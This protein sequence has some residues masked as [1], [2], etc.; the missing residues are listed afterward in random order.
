MRT[1]TARNDIEPKAMKIMNKESRS[2][3]TTVFCG[4]D[5]SAKTLAIAVQEEKESLSE[6]EFANT[7]TGRKALIAWLHK[8]KAL[9]RV[10]LEATG[11]YS[12]D[13]PGAQS[14]RR[15]R[16]SRLESQGGESV[17][18]DFKAFEN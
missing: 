16:G 10:C 5:V 3:Q 17:R 14:G 7:S 6:R 1:R 4:I 9:V 15:D 12:L 8:R 13:R 11:I 2:E 18:A